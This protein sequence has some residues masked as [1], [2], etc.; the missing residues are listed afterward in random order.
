MEGQGLLPLRVQGLVDGLG[1]QFE[2]LEIYRGE[3]KDYNQGVN[4]L[5]S[6]YLL[7]Q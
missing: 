2:R 7:L 5:K 3:C 6:G 1:S 4:Y